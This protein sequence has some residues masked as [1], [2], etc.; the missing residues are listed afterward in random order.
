MDE[1]GTLFVNVLNN[2]SDPEGD[3]LSITD[4]D[5]NVYDSDNNL[6]GTV[7]VGT[8]EIGQTGL[9][10]TPVGDYNGPAQ[11]EYT[12]SDGEKTDS[13]T[14][15]I[16][17]APVNDGPDAVDDGSEAEPLTMDQGD[18]LLIDVLANDTDPDNDSLSIESFDSNATDGNGNVVGTVQQVGDQLLF[19][20]DEGYDGPAHFNYAV[21]DGDLTDSAQVTL[22]VLSTNDAPKAVDDLFSDQPGTVNDTN[23]VTEGGT[24]FES[25]PINYLLIVD[26]SGSMS[27]NNRMNEAKAALNEMLETLQDQINTSGGSVKV[28]LIDFDYDAVARTYTL[29]DDPATTDYQ[30]ALNFIAGFN[31]SGATYYQTAL[32]TANTWVENESNGIETQVIFM[33]DGAPNNATNWQDE[34]ATLHST[35]SVT[36]VG[37]EMGTQNMQYINEIN[38]HGDGMDLS[39]PRDLNGLLRALLTQTSTE[40]NTATGNVLDNDTD[41][42]GDDLTVV[43]IALGEETGHEAFTS[44][45]DVG[46]GADDADTA[47]MTGTYGTL[48]INSDGTYEYAADQPAADELATGET[49]TEAFTY[50]VSDGQGGFDEA[51]LNFQIN[52]ADDAPVAVND[53]YAGLELTPGYW[54][55]ASNETS[56]NDADFDGTISYGYQGSYYK[57]DGF[58]MSSNGWTDIVHVGEDDLGISSHYG[59]DPN[60]DGNTAETMYISFAAPQ[61]SV[62]ITLGDIDAKDTPVFWIMRNDG[63]WVQ[64][65]NDMY[66]DGVFTATGNI[67]HIAIGANNWKKD[68]FYL[69]SLNATA[70]V[71][72]TDWI[73]ASVT[74]EGISGNVLLNDHDAE[75]TDHAETGGTGT[76][77]VVL[78]ATG[79]D[80]YVSLAE[81]VHDDAG[82]GTI[83][84]EY[85]TLT[86]NADGTF[87]YQV[88]SALVN[89]VDDP[90][91]ETF[92]YQI[93]DSDGMTSTATL[94]FPITVAGNNSV[95]VGTTGNDSLHGDG[96]D[97]VIFGLAGDDNVFIS[98]GN[99]TVTLGEGADTI[100]IDP[101][102][103]T[104]GDGT[105]TITDFNLGE[106][107]AFALDNLTNAISVEVSA[108]GMNNTDLNVVFSDL[109]GHSDMTVIL[110]GVNPDM[111]NVPDA[112]EPISSGDELNA[113]IQSI[114]NSGNDMNS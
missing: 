73:A 11:F 69:E 105:M 33:S 24:N 21:T 45:S 25:N 104:D 48:T 31:A 66:S 79:T 7:A 30:E 51:T 103:L 65:G 78:G 72:S 71:T 61:D 56:I 58:T 81:T 50:Q 108:S 77:L 53:V 109:N 91:V 68:S 111:N 74:P 41:P 85:G 67:R 32:Q 8:N 83:Q 1:D 97:N 75:D 64:G 4:F 95:I 62:T 49:R 100:T 84:G 88:D 20:P 80:G 42:D 44:L 18:T 90:G 13:A 114:I 35:T 5:E 46:A 6:I 98:S 82:T 107:D 23:I 93:A 113:L 39:D 87:Q 102:Y 106:N 9:I 12:I 10:F 57:G 22:N 27:Y 76:D 99:D 89:N 55:T 3:S 36:G 43:G 37:I 101:N 19:T 52:G 47:V 94:E 16:Q 54:H 40:G 63:N 26:T 92:E 110:Q 38:E 70:T 86:L 15:T 2:D 112:P 34:L 59:D 96:G 17:V 28:G 14:V 29:T 60:I